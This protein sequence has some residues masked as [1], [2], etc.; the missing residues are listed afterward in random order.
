MF[1]IW[2]RILKDKYGDIFEFE[3]GYDCKVIDINERYDIYFYTF[4]QPESCP[5]ALYGAIVADR[6]ENAYRYYTLEM[7]FD[8]S[9][10][11]GGKANGI[12]YNY[13]NLDS[14]APK[15]FLKWILDTLK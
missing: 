4:P 5:D 9:W 7:S 13:G 3:E 6:Q 2:E 10:V 1:D 11:I 14:S 15:A 12:H 8:G